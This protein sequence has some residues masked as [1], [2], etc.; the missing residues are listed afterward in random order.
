L[1]SIAPWPKT[2]TAFLLVPW[3]CLPSLWGSLKA[4]VVT[5]CAVPPPPPLHLSQHTEGAEQT[6]I[7]S[8]WGATTWPPSC[9]SSLNVPLQSLLCPCL[10]DEP[11]DALWG[12][13]GDSLYQVSLLCHLSP[14]LERTDQGWR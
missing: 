4:G 14:A 6:F 9:L 1:C 12:H 3:I 13:R 7:H 11:H 2:S 8:D 5:G 10:L